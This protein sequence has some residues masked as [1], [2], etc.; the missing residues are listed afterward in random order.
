LVEEAFMQCHTAAEVREAAK[1]PLGLAAELQQPDR[2]ELDDGVFELLGVTSGRRRKELI[3]RLYYEVASHFRSIR[4]VEVQK[5]E[6]RRHGGSNNKVSQTELALDAWNEADDDL[7]K[8]LAEWLDEQTGRAKVVNLPEGEVRLPAAR[9][10][11]EATTLFFGKNSGLS[12]VCAS[13]AEA[14]LLAAIACAGLR[15]P[16]SVPSAE[17]KCTALGS[18]LEARL[19]AAHARFEEL[20]RE[21]AGTDK[22]REQ[23]VEHPWPP[24]AVAR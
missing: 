20:A 9:H 1:L 8:P 17:K 4:I 22:L 11:F 16:V 19:A 6:Q 15:G 5:M 24:C 21:R 14:E 18:L 3:D 7:R 13:R 2:R 12:H 23:V 10:F